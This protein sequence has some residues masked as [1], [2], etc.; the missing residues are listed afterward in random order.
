[1]F[2]AHKV[3]ADAAKVRFAAAKGKRKAPLGRVHLRAGWT[4][5]KLPPTTS[6]FGGYA[7]QKS[8][9]LLG[10]AAQ[11]RL[12]KE[13]LKV[14][15]V[16]ANGLEVFSG[17]LDRG[18][19]AALDVIKEIHDVAIQRGASKKIFGT[20]T[21]MLVAREHPQV[22]N[23]PGI[24][25]RLPRLREELSRAATERLGR[26]SDKSKAKRI[27]YQLVPS[28]VKTLFT[29]L[30]K[31]HKMSHQKIKLSDSVTGALQDAEN[32]NPTSANLVR[33]ALGVLTI[34]GLKHM[35][36]NTAFFSENGKK[37]FFPAYQA[38]VG[39]STAKWMSYET[40]ITLILILETPGTIFHFFAHVLGRDPTTEDL[41]G[42][43]RQFKLI[44]KDVTAFGDG[45]V[46][47]E[48]GNKLLKAVIKG[49]AISAEVPGNTAVEKGTYMMNNP[50]I[51]LEDRYFANAINKIR[52]INKENPTALNA[53]QHQALNLLGTSLHAIE[54]W[55][56]G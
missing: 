44:Y 53:E 32:L 6:N 48:V 51:I 1:M 9:S 19:G 55:V 46:S 4:D 54:A 22:K 56:H 42:F 5:E 47:R 28:Y 18:V 29:K 45:N 52:E 20:D 30:N 8:V 25:E 33:N 23:M 40:A 26:M 24:N 27:K 12:L 13:F 17:L 41:L 36:P 34:A 10:P 11:K 50:V 49:A 7:N 14:D 37:T 16:S 35:N 15:K 39:S 43:Y 21:H 38:L 2:R 3:Y 31:I